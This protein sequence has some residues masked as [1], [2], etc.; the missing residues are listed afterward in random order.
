MNIVNIIHIG[1]EVHNLEDL[2][3]EKRQ[4]IAGKLC[5][6]ALRPLGYELAKRDKTA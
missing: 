5:L 4:E 6:Q 1:E 2:S 3:P